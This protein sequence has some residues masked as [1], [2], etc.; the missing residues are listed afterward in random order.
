M[1]QGIGNEINERTGA[2]SS[3]VHGNE[4]PKFLDLCMAPGGFPQFL[5][6]L[7]PSAQVCGISLPPSKGGHKL[8]LDLQD[9][10]ITL[11]FMDI[12]FLYT[13]MLDSAN[14]LVPSGH[15]D[16]GDFIET[17][18]YL[19]DVFDLV[20][21]DGQVLRTHKRAEYRELVE[22]TRLLVSQLVLALQ[23]IRAGGTIVVLLHKLETWSTLQL[24]YM[25]SK[26]SLVQLFK[27]EKCHAIRSSFYLI[28]KSV[29]PQNPHAV[30]AISTWE[31][32]LVVYYLSLLS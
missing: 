24:L 14:I 31:K 25:F 23:R 12:T 27:P 4:S 6:Q 5:L 9:S 16:A 8:F 7:N 21:C 17:R 11:N 10:R 26:F 29:Q 19:S 20:I 32:I 1:M 18:P 15:P 3:F 30:K 28:A 13:E 22:A 2:F